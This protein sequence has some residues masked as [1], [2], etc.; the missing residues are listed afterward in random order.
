M[1][2]LFGIVDYRKTLT[3]KQKN[4]ILSVLSTSCEI[5]GIDATGIAYNSHNKLCIYKRPVPAHCLHFQIPKD[6]QVIMGHTRMATQG[7]HLRNCNNHPFPGRA[8]DRAF[9][10]AH[11]GVLYN[12]QYLRRS[13]HLP[14]TKIETDSFIG[15]QLI[16]KR[17]TLDFFSLQYMAEQVEG[18]FSFSILDGQNQLY[19]VKG[20]NPLCLYHFQNIGLYFYASTEEILKKALAQ[21]WISVKQAKRV[22]VESGEI[23]RIDLNG[24]ITRSRFDD[25]HFTSAYLGPAFYDSRGR[26]QRIYSEASYLDEIKSVAAAFGYVPEAIDRLSALG[27]SPEELEEY[28]YQGEV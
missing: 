28:L 10:L 8:R 11:N 4:R 22:S 9:A 13:L 23:L 19:L 3:V 27:F 5:R 1:C 14:E 17:G 18:S 21:L 26:K 6:T 15:V 24:T 12:D 7:S 20:D 16:E 25:S 2:C